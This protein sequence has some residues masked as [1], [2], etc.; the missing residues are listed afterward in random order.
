VPHAFRPYL[1]QYPDKKKYVL[2]FSDLK[3]AGI[4]RRTQIFTSLEH[5]A[6]NTESQFFS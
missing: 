3:I 1:P 5:P 2:G 6:S 4:D